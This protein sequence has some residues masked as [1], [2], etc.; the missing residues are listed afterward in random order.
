MPFQSQSKHSPPD[1]AEVARQKVTVAEAELWLAHVEAACVNSGCDPVYCRV[2]DSL[3]RSLD[4]ER[5]ELDY[6]SEV[7]HA[8]LLPVAEASEPTPSAGCQVAAA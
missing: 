7:L 3:Q 1:A 6:L 5:A 8:V 4:S 2:R